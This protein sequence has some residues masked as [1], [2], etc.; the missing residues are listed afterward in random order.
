MYEVHLSI[1]S[2][3][4]QKTSCKGKVP[5]ERVRSPARERGGWYPGLQENLLCKLNTEKESEDNREYEV[6]DGP[7]RERNTERG[8]TL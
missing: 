4:G 6:R 8:G 3:T 1:L 7:R 2:K 5:G